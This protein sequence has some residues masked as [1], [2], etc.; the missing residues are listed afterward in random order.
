MA[1]DNR[2]KAQ[3]V[4]DS[5]VW[6]ATNVMDPEKNPDTIPFRMRIITTCSG[7][8]ANPR[9]ALVTIIPKLARSKINFLPFLSASFPQKGE[10]RATIR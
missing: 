4:L 2:P 9:S 8:C 5:G 1:A 7:L 10:T 3:P 6:V